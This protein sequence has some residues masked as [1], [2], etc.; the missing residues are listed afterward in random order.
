MVSNFSL[1][2]K[3]KNIQRNYKEIKILLY[4]HVSKGSSRAIFRK[5]SCPTQ[6][7][8]STSSSSARIKRN[9]LLSSS[10]LSVHS[11]HSTIT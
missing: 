5:V 2:V 7:A 4:E 3:V 6:I 1:N 9:A 10:L 8:A 11:T